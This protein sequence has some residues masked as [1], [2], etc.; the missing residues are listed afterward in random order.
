MIEAH[1][2]KNGILSKNN[3][4][5]YDVLYEGKFSD[6]DALLEVKNLDQYRRILITGSVGDSVGSFREFSDRINTGKGSTINITNI[7]S[8]S[9]Y[10]NLSIGV[11][12]KNNCI[13]INYHSSETWNIHYIDHIIGIKKL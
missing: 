6:N 1:L 12:F 13:R 9:F 3:N 8:T 10:E 5:L 11:D 7:G 4:D 2:G